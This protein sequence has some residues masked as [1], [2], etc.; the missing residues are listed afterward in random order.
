[1]E[2]KMEEIILPKI[3][4]VSEDETRG[5]FVIEPL[6]PGYGHSIANPLRRV[7]LSSLEG[8]AVSSIKIEGVP[9]EFST[10][11]GVKEDVI[12]IISNLKQI[13]LKL[14]GEGPATMNLNVRGPKEVKAL[15]IKAPS[16]I[17]IKNKDLYIATIDD[18]KHSLSI[19]M[20]V[21]KGR[22]YLPVEMKSEK[23]E[24]GVIQIDSIF[25]PVVGVSFNIENTRV[26]RRTDF[27]KITLEIKTD[28]TISPREALQKAA[29]I[30]VE[31]FGLIAKM[32]PGLE[33]EEPKSV[34]EDKTKKKEGKNDEEKAPK[35]KSSKKSAT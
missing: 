33:K 9:H 16:E 22:G 29:E 26:G 19:E 24:I 6:Y 18:N 34:D 17:E 3:Q 11:P 30:L 35:K 20:F 21:E 25:S 12:Q 28:G 15:D 13:R 14:F 4:V 7:L 23:P 32:S 2:V 8:A 5:V 27:N 1:M 31:Q 10:I